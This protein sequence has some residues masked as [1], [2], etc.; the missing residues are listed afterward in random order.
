[1]I[2]KALGE[3]RRFLRSVRQR[4]ARTSDDIETIPSASSRTA[5]LPKK[6]EPK[7]ANNPQVG[8]GFGAHVAGRLPGDPRAK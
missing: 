7:T 3:V 5:N 1:M 2:N 6:L 8:C 4:I